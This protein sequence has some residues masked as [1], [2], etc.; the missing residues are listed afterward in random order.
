ME[1]RAYISFLNTMTPRPCAYTYY[2]RRP[3][4]QTGE[5]SA[6]WKFFKN[7]CNS[8]NTKA[9]DLKIASFFSQNLYYMLK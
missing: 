7:R 8:Q 2:P 1:N 9:N 4:S 3:A 5:N 6:Q